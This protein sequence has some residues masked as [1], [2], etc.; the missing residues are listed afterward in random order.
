MG[1]SHSFFWL[2]TLNKM[3]FMKPVSIEHWHKLNTNYSW[4]SVRGSAPQQLCKAIYDSVKMDVIYSSCNMIRM[5]QVIFHLQVNFSFF[6][7]ARLGMDDLESSAVLP[8]LSLLHLHLKYLHTSRALSFKSLIMSHYANLR[9]LIPHLGP[10]ADGL[11]EE[12]SSSQLCRVDL[13]KRK[14]YQ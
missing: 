2:F 9:M 8:G 4:L 12:L 7:W 11:L 3:C 14:G 5:N 10:P 13:A 6:P 1:L